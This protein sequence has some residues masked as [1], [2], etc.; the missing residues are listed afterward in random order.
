MELTRKQEEGL[1][2]AVSRYTNHDPYTCIAG[3]AGTGKSTLVNFII[4]ALNIDKELVAYIAYTG[5]AS[6][7]LK[8]KGC[9]NAMTAH[10]LLYKAFPKDNGEFVY[11]IK[12]VLDAPYELIVVDEVSMLPQDMWDLLLSHHIYVL[13]LGDPGQLPPINGSNDV[14][15]H[16][17][18]FLDEVVRQAQESEIIRLSMDIRAGKPLNLYD[19]TDVKIVAQKDTVNGMYT[20]ADAILCGKNITRYKV[21]DLMRSYIWNT[22]DPTPVLGDKVICGHNDWKTLSDIEKQ[23]LVNGLIGTISSLEET[24]I[25][26]PKVGDIKL[27]NCGLVLEDGLDGYP[28]MLMDAKLFLEHTPT[29]TKDNFKYLKRIPIKPFEYAYAITCHKAQ[30]SEYDKV[31]VLEEAWPGQ[32]HI[33]WMYTAVTRAAKKLVIVRDYKS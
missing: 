23:P 2:I 33:R 30:G 11:K 24:E 7:V 27:Y 31:L 1:K 17:H 14:L 8:E 21:N 13:A 32:E 16:P 19:G 20:W 15:E 18:V 10:K 12:R 29:V 4:E 22:E 25:M 9:P 26:A 3:Y 28:P 5:K 6:L